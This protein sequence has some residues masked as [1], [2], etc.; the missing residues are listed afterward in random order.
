MQGAGNKH[1]NRIRTER[2][3]KMGTLDDQNDSEHDHNLR[4]LQLLEYVHRRIG[5]RHKLTNTS[6]FVRHRHRHIYV[7]CSPRSVS[8]YLGSLTNE[9]HSDVPTQTLTLTQTLR[10]RH[11]DVGCSPRIVLIYPGSRELARCP[12][13]TWKPAQPASCSGC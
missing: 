4:E 9:T 13:A 7:G 6:L 8:I 12:S 10:R 11:I 2:Q 3:G 1:R 5:E